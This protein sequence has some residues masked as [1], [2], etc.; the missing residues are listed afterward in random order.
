[1]L[2]L[3]GV[4]AVAFGGPW[5]GVTLAVVA[6]A[7]VERGSGTGVAVAGVWGW[8][9]GSVWALAGWEP[10]LRDALVFLLARV[11]PWSRSTDLTRR[12]VRETSA[13]PQ[14]AVEVAR[15]PPGGAFGARIP[16]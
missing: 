8:V 12:R 9:F 11:S 3:L 16:A 15:R 5:L 2:A 4:A 10:A 14:G 1:M 7:A 13:A 6:A